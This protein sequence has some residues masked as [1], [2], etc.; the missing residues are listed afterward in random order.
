MYSLWRKRFAG[1]SNERPAVGAQ[2]V[3]LA[4]ESLYFHQPDGYVDRRRACPLPLGFELVSPVLGR[5]RVGRMGSAGLMELEPFREPAALR[6]QQIGL[7][8][9]LRACETARGRLHNPITRRTAAEPTA[10]SAPGCA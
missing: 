10:G 4:T 2:I 6:C 5:A 1:G 8:R 3:R 7:L 9:S